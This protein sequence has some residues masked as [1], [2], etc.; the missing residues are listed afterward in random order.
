MHLQQCA[1]DAEGAQY[2]VAVTA[3]E[4]S[5]LCSSLSSEVLS[6]SSLSID[7]KPRLKGT[8]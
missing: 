1:R 3:D 2:T 4:K 7:K 8:R 6:S 5:L